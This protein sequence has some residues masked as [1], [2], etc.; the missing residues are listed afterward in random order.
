MKPENKD[1]LF[2][3]SSKDKRCVKNQRE[4]GK[5]NNLKT[6]HEIED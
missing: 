3:P 6:R 1:K 5:Q 2:R 4:F